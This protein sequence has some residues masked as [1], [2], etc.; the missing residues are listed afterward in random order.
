MDDLQEFDEWTKD[1]KQERR[2]MSYDPEKRRQRY[3]Q[4][5]A[6]IAKKYYE[7][8]SKYKK[9]T[10]EIGKVLKGDHSLRF[11]KKLLTMHV[12]IFWAKI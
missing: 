1:R 6:K 2:K 4:N 10:Q 7:N 9:K 11:S 8:I 12:P 3:K 5:K